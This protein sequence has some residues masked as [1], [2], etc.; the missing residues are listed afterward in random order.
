MG[1][2]IKFNEERQTQRELTCF[3]GRHRAAVHFAAIDVD[4]FG[5]KERGFRR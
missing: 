4:L 1:S 3:L 5:V 2:N